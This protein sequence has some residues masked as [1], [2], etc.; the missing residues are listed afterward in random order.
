MSSIYLVDDH[1]LLREGLRALQRWREQAWLE[2]DRDMLRTLREW[3][4]AGTL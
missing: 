1:A 4:G 3:Q 2:M